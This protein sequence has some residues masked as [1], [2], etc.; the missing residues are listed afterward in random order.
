MGALP[1]QRL[2]LFAESR[3][4]FEVVASFMGSV[5]AYQMREAEL[6]RELEKRGREVLRMLLQEHLDARGP[7]EVRDSVEAASGLE[8]DRKRLHERGLKTVVGPV[9][10][11]RTG[12]GAPGEA[13]LHPRD[14]ELN[15]P[16]QPYSFELQRRAVEEVSKA[17]FDSGVSSIDRLYGRGRDDEATV[18]PKRQMEELM[19]P[20]MEDFEPFYDGRSEAGVVADLESGSVLAMG[21]DGKGVV[22]VRRDLRPATREAAEKATPKMVSRMSKGEKRNRKRM[23][24]VATVFTVAPWVRTPEEVARS[25]VSGSS[26]ADSPDTSPKRPR[27]ENKRVWASLKKPM[28]TVIEEAFKEADG[29]DPEH[30]LTWVALSDGNAEQLQIVQ[31][32]AR[33]MGVA[34]IVILDLIHVLEYLWKAGRAFHKES[35]KEIEAWVGEQLLRVLRGRSS[36]VAAAMR[37]S[38]TRRGL[39]RKKR[40]RVDTCAQYLL[41]H[42]DYLHY[43]EY[44]AAG[45]PITTGA[46]EG[47]VRHLVADRMDIT[48]ARWTLATAE[49]VLRARALRSSGDLDEYWT[50]HEEQEY[51]R[52]HAS[53]YANHQPPATEPPEWAKRARFR[54]V[55]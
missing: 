48:G 40:K 4:T 49:A 9:R 17:S 39:T 32:R 33:V 18:I 12:Y 52:N 23:A 7:G 2:D 50:Y 53:R 43:D 5:E 36:L 41:N 20:A 1:A 16:S 44:L 6:E 25:L 55:K 54:R 38:A 46:V 14:A 3:A 11:S 22:M 34:L 26:T 13:S 19:A 42:R 31:E 47:T 24:E 37:R 8:L 21:L 28:G 27:P 10:V 15:L 30:R 51:Q 45:L 29:R 35:S